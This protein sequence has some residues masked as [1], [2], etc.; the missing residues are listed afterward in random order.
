MQDLL[1]YE[2][3]THLCVDDARGAEKHE[4][5]DHWSDEQS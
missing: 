1:K 2:V 4:D 5:E 3:S